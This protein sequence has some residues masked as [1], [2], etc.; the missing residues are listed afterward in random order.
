MSDHEPKSAFELAMEKLKA[1][2]REK[3]TAPPRKLSGK[4]KEKIAEIR[5][6]YGSKLAE[7]E[8]LYQD[9]LSKAGFDAEKR[10]EVEKAYLEDRERMERERDRKIQEVRA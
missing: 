7:R 5:S 4:E 6:F 10:A 8:I 9:E 1:M 3:G 2:D